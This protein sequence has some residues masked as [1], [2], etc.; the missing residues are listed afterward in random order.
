MRADIRRPANRAVLVAVL[1]LAAA[2]AGCSRRVPPPALPNA[3]KHPDFV[4]P[5]VPQVLQTAPGVEHIEPGWRHLQNDDLRAA[6]REFSAALKRSP[7]LYPAHAGQGYVALAGN[8]HERALTSFEAAIAAAADYVPAL[9]GRGQVFLAMKRDAD[10]LR[11]FESALAANPSLSDVQ[12]RVEVLRFRNV[13]QTIEAARTAAAAGRLDDSRGAYERALSFTP[14]SAFLYRELA[15]VER[16]QNN[17]ERALQHFRKA[18]ELDPSDAVSLVGIGDLLGERQDFAGAESAYRRAATIEP[19]PGLTAKI[20]AVAERGREARLPAEYRAIPGAAQ[21]TRG[22][23]AALIG[24]R[25]ERVLASA[26][27]RQVVVTDTRDHWAAD[28]ITRVARAGV[29]EP[30]ENHTFQPRAQ[31]RRGDLAAA[32]SRVINLLAAGD[33][34]LRKRAAERP[35]IADMNTAH[36]SYPAAATAVSSGVLPLLDGGR[37]EVSRAV[38]GAEAV[39]AIERLRVMVR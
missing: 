16:R 23:L 4:Y 25:L 39:E 33:P 3:V 30:F 22:D 17:A 10:A 21:I 12:R 36:L 5:A 1:L 28:W 26:P 29:L 27:D 20:A 11:S 14:D 7:S 6:T 9:V 38:S 19:D 13:Q 18:V 31:V 34:A 24:V 37:F 15:L 2:V 32:V 35:A 8:D